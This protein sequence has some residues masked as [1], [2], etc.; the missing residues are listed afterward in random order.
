VLRAYLQLLRPANV[1]TALADV[2]A[3]FAVG[4]LQNRPALPWL[5]VA[6]ACLYAGGVVLNDFFDRHTDR[7]ERPER[8]IPSGRVPAAAAAVLGAALLL[9]GWIAASH[10]ATREAGQIALAIVIAVVLYDAWGK[11]STL[12]GPVNMGLCRALNLLLGVAAVPAAL[13][14]AWPLAMIPLLYIAAVTALSRGEVHGGSSR[15]ATIALISLSAALLALLYVALT[16][17]EWF[18]PAVVLVAA[19][20]W[21]VLPAFW[22]ARR[23]PQPGT[24]RAAVK[25]GVLS[26]VLVDATIGAAYAGPTY[27]AAILATA[28]VAGW[29]ARWFAVT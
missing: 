5:L 14:G 20:A 11:R 18:W 23:Q 25:R 8:P 10:H 22:A 1:V 13:A 6:T 7:V 3:G 15:I 24:I 4:G 19:L 26:L 9:A 2:L 17:G 12:V 28:L 27:A 16:T 21:R 29:L